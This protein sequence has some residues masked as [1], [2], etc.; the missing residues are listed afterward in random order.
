MRGTGAN[1][2]VAILCLLSF[3]NACGGGGGGGYEGGISALPTVTSVSP[4]DS[5]TNVSTTASVSVTF[6]Q[7][8]NASTINS[9]TFLVT[10]GGTQV[11]GTILA[12]GTIYTF[13]PSGS[14]ATNTL[15]TVTVTTGVQDSAGNGMAA[16]FTSSFTTASLADTT[17]PT[18]STVSPANAATNV[19][20][21]AVV[22]VTFSEAMNASTITNST[23]VVSIGG[24]PVA[25]SIS[26]TGT[27]YTFTPSTA[28]IAG[29]VYAISVTTGAQDVGG[30]AMAVN[31]I[32]SFTTASAGQIVGVSIGDSSF[33]PQAIT[34]NVGDTVTWTNNGVLVHTSTRS[35][36]FPWDSGFMSP[37]QA[38]SVIFTQSGT[39]PYLCTTHGFTGTVT[40]Q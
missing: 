8:M 32:S 39:F 37:G 12:S 25:G 21:T 38:F 34:I 11:P 24:N 20:T 22:S 27:T 26:A 7:A 1:L 15:Y 13:A 33:T 14:L 36:T 3:V 4:A 19:A 28:L 6:S 31:F 30:N 29:A 10:A 40:V 23:F 16:N 5:A 35:G 9:A 18:V 2:L 17:P